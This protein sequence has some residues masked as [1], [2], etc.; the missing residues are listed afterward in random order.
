LKV[1]TEVQAAHGLQTEP[2]RGPASI[3]LKNA[4]ALG[5]GT[6]EMGNIDFVEEWM[7]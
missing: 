1:L 4:A 7:G 5:I 3:W 2:I 6:D